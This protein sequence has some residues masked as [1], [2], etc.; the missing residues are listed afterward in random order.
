MWFY[1]QQS[2]V[3]QAVEDLLITGLDIAKSDKDYIFSDFFL[4]LK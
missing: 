3:K 2:P 1:T 4:V